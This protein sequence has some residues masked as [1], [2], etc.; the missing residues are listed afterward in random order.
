MHAQL[1]NVEHAWTVGA[2]GSG[3]SRGAPLA[4]RPTGQTTATRTRGAPRRQEPPLPAVTTNTQFFTLDDGS[5]PVTG[6]RPL[7]P[8]LQ[9][10]VQRHTVEHIIDVLPFVRIL[11]VPVPQLGDQLVEFGS[12]LRPPRQN[13]E[14]F[15]GPASSAEGGTVG[16]SADRTVSFLAP[17]AECRAVR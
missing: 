11:D 9:G 5:V 13:P 10:G 7:E 4:Q 14:A 15:C 6:E 2:Q 16:G 17:A 1:N 3:V 8:R 12:T